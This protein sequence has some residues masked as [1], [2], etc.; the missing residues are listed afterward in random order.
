MQGIRVLEVAQFTFVPV[1]GAVLAEWGADVIKVEHAEKGDAQRGLLT[2]LGLAGASEGSSFVPIMEGPN[3][4]KRSIGLALEKPEGRATLLEMAKECDVFLTNFTPSAREK[5]GITLEDIRAVNPNIIYTVGSAFGPLGPD[6]RKGGYDGSAFWARG[7]SAEGATPADSPF[8]VNQPGGA[9]GDNVGGLTIAGAIVT[10]L[11]HRDRTGEATTVD[12]SLLGMGAW[13]TQFNINLAMMV[14]GHLPKG[15]MKREG[16][17]PLTHTY[18][19]QDG[20]WITLMMLQPAAYWAETCKTLGL[21]ELIDDPRFG[22]SEQIMANAE[23]AKRLFQAHF[24][25]KTFEEWGTILHE[26]N[27][28]WAPVQDGWDMASDPDLIA[29]GQIQE[30]VDADGAPRRLVTNPILFDKTPLP[31]TR[32]P[33][34][35]EHTDEILTEFGLS[36]EQILDLK[37]AGAVT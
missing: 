22:S 29:N 25:T 12:V 4:G 26:L 21:P 31:T 13:A 3:R 30:V 10:A 18:E 6:A 8:L 27:G 5:L 16:G 17:N 34:F 33:Q 36:E 37:I 14:G 35:A 23:E 7:G 19:T 15:P 11:F 24:S 2:V 9:Y 1:A 20:R 32:A 28:Q